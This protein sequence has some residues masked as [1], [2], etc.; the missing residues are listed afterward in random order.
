MKRVVNIAKNQDGAYQWD[1]KQALA[2]SHEE[3]Q[4]VAAVLKQRVYGKRPDLKEW[5]KKLADEG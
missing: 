1:I 5:K 4:Q 2:M 3:R